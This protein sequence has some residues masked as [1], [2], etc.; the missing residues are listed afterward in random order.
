M[1]DETY[2]L[3]FDTLRQH[4]TEAG[5]RFV[6]DDGDITFG[7]HRIGLSIVF[8]GFTQQES[9]IIAPLDVQIHLD[10]DPGDRFRVG[11]LG[12]GRD[13]LTA[14]RSAIEEWHVLAAAPLLAALG[15]EAGA[16]RRPKAA[17]QLAGW[18]VFPGRAGVRGTLPPGLDPSGIFYRLLFESLYK[19]V[20][21]WP[22]PTGFE[23]RSI[24][25]MVTTA[26]GEPQIQAAI[27]GF[28]DE[29]LAQELSQLPWPRPPE[30]YLFKQLLVLRHGSSAS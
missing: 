9:Q 30:P 8:E 25:L 14:I 20:L 26:E 5:V 19:V 3:V 29:P 7:G 12:V 11:T 17:R 4:L 22:R 18:D 1:I 28:V 15:A 10:G 21:K 2:R 6:E 13:R 23:L 16:R 27:D 24:F